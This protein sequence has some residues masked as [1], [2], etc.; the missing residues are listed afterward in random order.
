MLHVVTFNNK[1]PLHECDHRALSNCNFYLAAMAWRYG[2]LLEDGTRHSD[3]QCRTQHLC[4]SVTHC[5]HSL[6]Q[7]HLY[8]VVAVALHQL[9]WW[10]DPY[11][12]TLTYPQTLRPEP[13][14]PGVS[15]QY[16]LAAE[17]YCLGLQS[18][19]TETLAPL[20]HWHITITC[21]I[22]ITITNTITTTTT[23]I[24][25]DQRHHANRDVQAIQFRAT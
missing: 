20:L 24:I 15:R 23:T 3:E 17:F 1:A 11:K 14:M 2:H 25:Q 9:L 16:A 12:D 18:P 5:F 22:T 10:Q 13:L 21:T 4:A 19:E 7:L 8:F 6:R